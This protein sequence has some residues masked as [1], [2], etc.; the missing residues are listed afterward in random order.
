MSDAGVAGA[1]RE[2]TGPETGVCWLL[3][4]AWIY[5]DLLVDLL[6]GIGGGG[7]SERASGDTDEFSSA[8]VSVE[9]A[10]IG[11]KAPLFSSTSL[12][13]CETMAGLGPVFRR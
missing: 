6:L 7:I 10:G 5:G 2:S 1:G 3:D 12:S 9:V 13:T 8:E 11:R 4:C